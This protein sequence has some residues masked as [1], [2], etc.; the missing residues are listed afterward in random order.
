MAA[1][2][3]PKL[4]VFAFAVAV[5]EGEDSCMTQE[6]HSSAQATAIQFIQTRLAMDE[7]DRREARPSVRP[8]IHASIV[9]VLPVYFLHIPKAG[10]TELGASILLLEHVC[11]NLTHHDIDG[12]QSPLDAGENANWDWSQA[13]EDMC[14]VAD[15]RRFGYHFLD[16]S[17]IGST[18]DQYAK[19]HG[20]RILRQP[21]Q[22]ILSAWGY[23]YHS[24]P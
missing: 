3:F 23:A 22:R 17:G 1:L 15:M 20:L 7:E 9:P 4:L 24:W 18:Y 13:F 8:S 19:G 10:G 6:D 21:E 14:S 2:A 16:H 12:L 11:W 5:A